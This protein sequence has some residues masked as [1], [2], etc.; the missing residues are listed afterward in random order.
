MVT[1][2]FHVF[3]YPAFLFA[4]FELRAATATSVGAGAMDAARRSLLLEAQMPP[5]AAHDARVG[6]RI[7]RAVSLRPARETDSPIAAITSRCIVKAIGVEHVRWAIGCT[8]FAHQL[9]ALGRALPALA[10]VA[11][12]LF[13]F[14]LCHTTRARVA[15]SAP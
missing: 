9:V 7:F 8:G 2:V 12:E 10:G 11:V 14:F 1:M 5:R 13:R 15:S 4:P 6:R 3:L